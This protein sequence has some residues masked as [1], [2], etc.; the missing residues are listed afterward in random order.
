MTDQSNPLENDMTPFTVGGRVY[1]APPLVLLTSKRAWP[2]I[3]LLG[4]EVLPTLPAH[5]PGNPDLGEPYD[6]D[7]WNPLDGQHRAEAILRILLAALS[8]SATRPSLN[9][10]E[11]TAKRSEY[12]GLADSFEALLTASGYD[13]AAPGEAEAAGLMGTSTVS[14]LSSPPT[15]SAAAI[16]GA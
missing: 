2:W 4:G 12:R 16:Q 8:L 15:A 5:L 10:L 6:I 7:P 3:K 9:E 11:M 14:P 1:Q 13:R